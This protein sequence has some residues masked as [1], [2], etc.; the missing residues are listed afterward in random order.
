MINFLRRIWINLVGSYSGS[1]KAK[2]YN[3]E[4]ALIGGFNMYVCDEILADSPVLNGFDIKS[5][6]MSVATPLDVGE[7]MKSYIVFNTF[8]VGEH[9]DDDIL[10]FM[11]YHEQGHLAQGHVELAKRAREIGV[12]TPEQT[13]IDFEVCADVSGYCC[14]PDK[15]GFVRGMRKFHDYIPQ[16]FEFTNRMFRERRFM[17]DQLVIMV[18]RLSH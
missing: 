18:A 5:M 2:M 6:P 10:N 14:S 12:L 15:E 13:A 7:G 17:V 11:L 4:T 3:L 8:S 9:R 16:E 1:A